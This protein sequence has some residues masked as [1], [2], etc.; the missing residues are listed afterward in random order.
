M[1]ILFTGGGTGGHFYPIIAVA[2]AIREVAKEKK[3]LPPELYYFAPTPYNESILFEQSIVY[4]KVQ[5]GKMRRYFSLLNFFDLWRTAWGMLSAIYKVYRLYPDVV[6][7]K[8]G[9]ASFP[10][11][12]AAKILHIPVVIHESDAVPG[13]AN[14]WAGKFAE[15]I[16]VSWADAAKYFPLSKV[17]HTGNPVRADIRQR[18]TD[19]GKEFM[20]VEENI[21]TVLVL[22]G[23]QGAEAINEVVVEALP[24]LVKD[25]SVIHQ[26]GK[27]NITSS[28]TTADVI[29]S[30]SPNKDRYKPVD[31]LN[32]LE[33]RMAAGAADIVVSR[34]GSTI[35]EIASWGVPSIIV[36]IKDSNGDHQRANAF[37]YARAGACEV[38]EE[39]NLT[40]NILVA[41]IR[42]ILSTTELRDKMKAAAKAFDRADASKKVAEEI[43]KIGLSHEFEN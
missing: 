2:E 40:A 24:E 13:R 36:P 37:S 15:K 21:P 29:L 30:K 34:A 39:D 35:F 42:R 7:G 32:G 38:V 4:K 11:L 25:Y 1:R 5:A 17:A 8:G 28:K 26:T 6:F 27:R 41:E 43:L 20:K 18:K 19:G 33:L 3:L 22:G 10:V 16:A 14:L 12:F 23:S 9:Y 31:Y